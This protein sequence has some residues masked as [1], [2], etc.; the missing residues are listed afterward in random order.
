[1]TETKSQRPDGGRAAGSGVWNEPHLFDSL[2]L[3]RSRVP[4]SRESR[5]GWLGRCRGYK[6]VAPTELV[7][8]AGISVYQCP[9]VV[10]KYNFPKPGQGCPKLPKPAQGGGEGG[11]VRARGGHNEER[12]HDE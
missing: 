2:A 11:G 6:Y 4:H 3:G 5:V 7:L 10:K 8:A 12:K 9:S 1:M